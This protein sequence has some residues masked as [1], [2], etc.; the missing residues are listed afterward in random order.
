MPE[1]SELFPCP[2]IEHD[3]A[4]RGERER[5]YWQKNEKEE[6]R[7]ITAATHISVETPGTARGQNGDPLS[8][9]SILQVKL[10]LGGSGLG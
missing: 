1:S 10:E 3:A 7:L 4:A 8:C 2:V 9:L 5:L 6:C